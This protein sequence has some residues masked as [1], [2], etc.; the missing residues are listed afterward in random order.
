MRIGLVCPYSVTIPGGVQAQVLGLARSLRRSGHLVRVLAPCDGP[1]PDGGVTPLGNSIPTAANGSVAP[2]APDL[3]AQLRFI[4]AV[5]DEAFD[6][7]HLHEPLCPGATM[8]ACV[9]KPTPLVGTFHAAGASASYSWL[10]PGV[11]WLA[12]RLD[13]RCTVSDDA[14][15]LASRHLGGEYV[16]LFNGIE[17]EPFAKATPSPTRGPTI[18]FLGRHEPRKGLA[19]LLEAMPML[20]SDV[21]LWVGGDGPET[22]RLRARA[23]GDP[24]IEWLGRLGEAEKASRMRGADVYCAPSIGGESFGVVLLEAMASSTPIVASD[25]AGYRRVVRPGADALLVEPGDAAALAAALRRVLGE[26]ALADA[27]VESG[28]QRA[29]EFSMD[30]LA[31]RYV[32]R[33]E[34]VTAAR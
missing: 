30:A 2:L 27:L 10:G 24:R 17:L 12:G 9:L 25:L 34:Q 32:E 3:P 20:P 14:H 23:A 26:P 22:E 13:L 21:R 33:Y 4:R 29:A 28:G 5:R 6:L 15:Q 8:T 31:D 11:R 7:L 18:L 19:V 16:M 1:P